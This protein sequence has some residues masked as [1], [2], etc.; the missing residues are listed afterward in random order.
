LGYKNNE[1]FLRIPNESHKN[2]YEN[3]LYEKKAFKKLL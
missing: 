3:N 2:Q 1:E